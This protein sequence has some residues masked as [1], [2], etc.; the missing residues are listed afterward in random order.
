MSSKSKTQ[1]RLMSWALACKKGKAKNCPANIKK[2]GD[3]MTQ[4]QLKD[5]TKTDYN[6]LPDIKENIITSFEKFNEEIVYD[7]DSGASFW[8][9]LASGVLPLCIR[10]KRFLVALRSKDVNEPNCWNLWSGKLDEDE[11]VEVAAKR[12]FNE[13]SGYNGN[14]K[15]IPAYIFK[16][17]GFQFHNFIGL[18][19][20]EYKP[21]LNWETQDY[22]WMTFEELLSL[23]PKHFG[24]EKLLNDK[25]S[26]DII[27]K[28][29]E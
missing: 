25:E 2:V 10:T 15:L 3:S 28:F 17:K 18:I 20:N 11:D 6:E 21:T 29:I 23:K 1:K 14:I 19:P 9:N 4:K 24:L 26:I 27:K 5:F 12:E 22:K 7:N 8:G 16:T 13:E